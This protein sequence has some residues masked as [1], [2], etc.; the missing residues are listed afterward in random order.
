MRG[1]HKIE[2]FIG[3]Y[4]VKGMS[5]GNGWLRLGGEQEMT[6]SHMRKHHAGREAEGVRKLEQEPL[7]WFLWKENRWGRISRPSLNNSSGL[8]VMAADSSCV[9]PGLG[10]IRAGG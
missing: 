9:V 1:K 7:L 10:V 8:W 5:L 2:L 3:T 6:W 4:E